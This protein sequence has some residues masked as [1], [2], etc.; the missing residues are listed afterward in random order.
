MNITELLD[1][2]A[3]T[4]ALI[5]KEYT[6]AFYGS[7]IYGI[8]VEERV[9]KYVEGAD[10]G[11]GFSL[12]AAAFKGLTKKHTLTT[13]S[14]D[15]LYINGYRLDTTEHSGLKTLDMYP[16]PPASDFPFSMELSYH[17]VAS[18]AIIGE[19]NSYRYFENGAVVSS[20]DVFRISTSEFTAHFGTRDEPENYTIV[21]TGFFK[22]LVLIAKLINK[23]GFSLDSIHFNVK[24]SPEDVRARCVIGDYEL[25]T[26]TIIGRTP[27]LLP[28]LNDRFPVLQSFDHEDM[29]KAILA[30]KPDGTHIEILGSLVDKTLVKKKL[31]PI[32]KLR[33]SALVSRNDRGL[34]AFEFGRRCTVL[35]VT[36]RNAN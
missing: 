13:L 20:N 8:G 11:D 1:F 18:A 19:D 34:L 26:K 35:C 28:L 3:I 4:K 22:A 23:K 14:K 6:I 24:F 12:E 16:L 29:E 30:T 15:G 2:I 25:D 32:L 21:P 31:Y 27:P 17:R 36:K 7:R 5:G 9:S 10:F 33:P